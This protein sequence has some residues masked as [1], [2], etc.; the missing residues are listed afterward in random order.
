MP[1]PTPD[2]LASPISASTPR[3]NEKEEEEDQGYRLMDDT[4]RKIAI[5]ETR[6]KAEVTVNEP[7]DNNVDIVVRAINS[8]SDEHRAMVNGDISRFEKRIALGSDPGD[9]LCNGDFADED[10]ANNTL[11]NGVS[12]EIPRNEYVQV[13]MN[14]NQFAEPKPT[15]VS[16]DEEVIQLK[17]SE[18]SSPRIITK[19]A[20]K[21]STQCPAEW[22]PEKPVQTNG[23]PD[24]DGV[25]ISYS[26]DSSTS[27]PVLPV[28]N[29]VTPHPKVPPPVHRKPAKRGGLV[30]DSDAVHVPPS[31]EEPA[32]P[33][34]RGVHDLVQRYSQMS[35]HSP[36]TTPASGRRGS[37]SSQ[38]RKSWDG[39]KEFPALEPNE[40]KNVS[41]L[42]HQKRGGKSIS[43]SSI[44]I[45]VSRTYTYPPLGWG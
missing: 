34:N 27:E 21:I 7:T 30:E 41:R 38:T 13:E 40:S 44:L 22:K 8:S 5:S 1:S 4:I 28:S 42:S 3:H 29:G 43:D 16:R 9:V 33:T 45:K 36:E 12:V 31:V 20:E 19:P 35:D 10:S 18:N 25:Q 26:D 2:G 23:E 17:N 39:V 6:T 37:S 24:W 14:N 15:I 32:T 11:T